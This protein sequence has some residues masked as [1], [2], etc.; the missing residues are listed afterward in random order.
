MRNVTGSLTISRFSIVKLDARNWTNEEEDRGESAP[1]E[2]SSVPNW[3]IP[4]F[5]DCM[6]VIGRIARSF[7]NGSPSASSDSMFLLTIGMTIDEKRLPYGSFPD[8]P[9]DLMGVQI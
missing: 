2:K 5:P 9:A 4:S 8:A 3:S 1:I 7:R 6:D